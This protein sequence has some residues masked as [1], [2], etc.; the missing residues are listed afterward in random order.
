[1][2]QLFITAPRYRLDNQS[3]WLRGIDPSRGYW[4]WVNGDV[5]FRTRLPG[6]LTEEVTR[7]QQIVRQF[8]TLEPGSSMGLE[9]L[10]ETGLTLHCISNNCYAIASDYQDAPVWHLFDHETLQSLLMTSHPDWQCAPEDLALGRE[11]LT[12]AFSHPLAA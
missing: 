6:L 7:W 9:R 3:P 1:M 12:A 4:L 10:N 2:V 11:L 5:A 8:H